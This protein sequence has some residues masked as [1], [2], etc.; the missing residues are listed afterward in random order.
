ML[1]SVLG[2]LSVA[3]ACASKP[4]LVYEIN[5][6]LDPSERYA[7][8]F[9]LNPAW[10]DT[11]WKFYNQHF[12]NNPVLTDVLYGISDARGPENDEAQAEIE[13][14]AAISNLPLAF[15]QSIRKTLAPPTAPS[16]ALL[17]APNLA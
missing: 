2:L 9:D 12:A 11:V 15:V 10:N 17:A 6:D 1:K 4:L 14:L 8:L 7:G 5:L 13:A 16:L 3:T